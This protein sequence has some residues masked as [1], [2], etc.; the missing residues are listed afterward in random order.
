MLDGEIVCLGKKDRPQ[1]RDLLFYRGDPCFF[2]FDMRVCDG[3]DWRSEALIDRKQ[4]LRRL[5][6]RSPLLLS[7]WSGHTVVENKLLQVLA[8]WATV[9]D[10]MLTGFRFVKRLVC[11]SSV[12]SSRMHLIYRL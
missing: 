5:L 2:A 11:L 4:E 12:L 3:K 1:F 10:R 8:R 7:R 9:T 6:G